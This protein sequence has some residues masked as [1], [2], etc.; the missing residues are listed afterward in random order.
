MS[1]AF[2]L[3]A[4]PIQRVLWDMKWT[5]L[6][7]IQNDAIH[8]V[9]ESD[10]DLI[11]SARTASGKTEA[12][13]LP[14]L[15]AVYD[16]ID[17]SIRAIYV[18]PLKAL[19]NDQFRR[20][21][22]LCVHANIPVHRWH[23]D[24]SASRKR[25]LIK[26]PSGILLITP[27]SLESL[28]VNHSSALKRMFRKLSFVVI[29][30][31][32]AMYGNERGT[33]LRSLL[34]RL[35][36]L[37]SNSPSL[38]ALS[39]TLGDPAASARW[40]R[41]DSPGRVRVIDDSAS[42]KSIQYGIFAYQLDSPSQE[43]RNGAADN[44]SN[45]DVAPPGALI[46]DVYRSFRSD[47]GLIFANSRQDVEWFADA[48]N[49][50][51]SEEGAQGQFLVHH[52]SLSK[53]VR[54]H[55]ESLMQGSRP[56]STL[57]TSSLELGIDIGN[58][59]CVGQIGCPY[60]VSALVQRLGRSGRRDDQAQRMRFYLLEEQLPA[61]AALCHRLRPRLLQS[62]AMT[63]LMLDKWVEPL[64][65]SCG[66]LSTLTQQVLSTIKE[67]GGITAA[68]LY[69][70][71]VES[72]AFRFV[73][74]PVFADVLRSIGSHDLIEQAPDGTLVLGLHG[75]EIVGHYDFYSAFATSEEFRVVHSGAL[76]GTLPTLYVPQPNTHLLLAGR[77]WKVIAVDYECREIHVVPGHGRKLPRFDGGGGRVH[78]RVREMMRDVLLSDGDFAYINPLASRLLNE[79]RR[80]AAEANL[81]EDDLIELS[82]SRTL[83]FTWE[84][85]H[86]QMTLE[87]MATCRKIRTHD[88]EIAIEFEASPNDVRDA[89]SAMLD[90]PPEA[91]VLAKLQSSKQRRKFDRHLDESLLEWSL[92]REVI[93][94]EGASRAIQRLLSATS[95]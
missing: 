53:E 83:W 48:L 16:D 50:R 76:I 13:F 91:A 9:L 86:Q 88:W 11:I 4:R 24:V 30:E 80:V 22:D 67:T 75:E 47:K 93:D 64:E 8:I 18:G 82:P 14:V 49:V 62:I 85:T 6:R 92:V 29:D 79:A 21:E 5:A 46:E 44:E 54:E 1:S 34:F 40:M 52:G 56:Y 81:A 55:T 45:E 87:L 7:P 2:D 73:D 61:D 59:A 31:L 57:C 23:G 70:R 65:D 38:I 74:K 78:R 3:L 12:A 19:I 63:E 58:V 33:H 25:S 51:A 15:S 42:Q 77:R 26:Q 90:E 10:E 69:H 95:K 32:H 89:Y 20:L 66:D 41:P 17:A 35:A 60:S 36:G 72:G 37:L 43:G 28:F 84:G 27:E 94:I 39:A 71:L 68:D